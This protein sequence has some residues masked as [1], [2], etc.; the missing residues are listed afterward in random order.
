MS[1]VPFNQERVRGSS[2]LRFI[3]NPVT[4]FS[5]FSFQQLVAGLQGSVAT[6]CPWKPRHSL[7]LASV[8]FKIHQLSP[9]LI[10]VG[11]GGPLRDNFLSLFLW[12]QREHHFTVNVSQWSAAKAAGH[13]QVSSISFWSAGRKIFKE[14]SVV[15]PLL[16]VYIHTVNVQVL[17]KP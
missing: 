10:R 17:C 14:M 15:C 12:N 1:K 3:Q 6:T 9:F 5:H 13:V 7:Y 4:V 16:R 8:A 2:A 11:C